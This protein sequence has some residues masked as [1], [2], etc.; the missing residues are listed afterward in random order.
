[1]FRLGR[2][3]L[4]QAVEGKEGLGQDRYDLISTEPLQSLLD[5]ED[6]RE[7]GW[8]QVDGAAAH[9]VRKEAPKCSCCTLLRQNVA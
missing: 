5:D 9:K 7:V 3:R 8:E 6:L 2:R 1:M 4:A